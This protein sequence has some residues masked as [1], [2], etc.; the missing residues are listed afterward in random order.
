MANH[1]AKAK[2]TNKAPHPK[3]EQDPVAGSSVLFSPSGSRAGSEDFQAAPAIV[4][5][6]HDDA[7]VS[8]QAFKQTGSGMDFYENVQMLHG[9]EKPEDVEGPSCWWPAKEKTSGW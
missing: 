3:K 9:D 7:C 6:V 5:A 2:A 8:V 4:V 1:K